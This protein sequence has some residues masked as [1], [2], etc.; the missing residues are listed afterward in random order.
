PVQ[1]VDSVSEVPPDQT[2]SELS[3]PDTRV[4]LQDV[5]QTQD[6]EVLPPAALLTAASV[7]VETVSPEQPPLAPSEPLDIVADQVEPHE[8]LGTQPGEQCQ[9]PK[10]LQQL[11]VAPLRVQCFGGR[12]VWHGGDLL[13]PRPG[14]V[15]ETG[16][17][18]LLIL[19]IHRIAGVQAETLVDIIWPE[20]AP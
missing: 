20:K 17:E 16:W 19:A 18:L 1:A 5:A 11:R 15:E 13:W 2:A 4:Q 7:A 8:P 6:V 3:D 9:E 10:L 12:G 14:V